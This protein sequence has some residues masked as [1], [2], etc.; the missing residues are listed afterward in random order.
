MKRGVKSGEEPAEKEEFLGEKLRRA[1]KRGGQTT[2]T[3]PF[4][5]SS[6]SSSKPHTTPFHKHTAGVADEQGLAQDFAQRDSL[7][8]VSV[9]KLGA[10]LWELYH[11]TLPLATMHNGAPPPRLRRLHHRQQYADHDPSPIAPEL[12]KVF[13]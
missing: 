4:W 10:T 5:R 9:R 3:A 7:S 6:S 13:F 1:V 8:T 11:Y 2:P 12:V